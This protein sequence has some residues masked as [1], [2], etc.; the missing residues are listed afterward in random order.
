MEELYLLTVVTMNRPVGYETQAMCVFARGDWHDVLAL[1]PSIR[2]AQV[3]AERRNQGLEWAQKSETHWYAYGQVGL[4]PVI[5]NIIKIQ[6]GIPRPDV[7]GWL[8]SLLE[9]ALLIGSERIL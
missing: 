2:E 3:C 4:Q 7:D 8:Q 5:W 6:P 9:E 1:F